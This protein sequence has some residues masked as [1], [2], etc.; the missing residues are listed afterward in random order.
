MIPNNGTDEWMPAHTLADA[1]KQTHV[2]Y[3][4]WI[5]AGVMVGVANNRSI[6]IHFNSSQL[7]VPLLVL[8]L[9]IR[10]RITGWKTGHQTLNESDEDSP[11]SGSNEYGA[12]T[13]DKGEIAHH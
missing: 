3:A 13:K 6:E 10:L 12:I 11:Y 7:P 4:F 5:M 9:S 8:S 2:Q 1:Q